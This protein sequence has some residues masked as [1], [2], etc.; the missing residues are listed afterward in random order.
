MIRI[1]DEHTINQ[2]AAGEVIENPASVIKELVDNSLDAGATSIIIEATNSGRQLIS[3]KDN[4]HGMSRDDALLCLERYATS[5]IKSIDDL[6]NLTTMGFRGEA[7][8]S[9]AA[10][11]EIMLLTAKNDALKPIVDGTML[12][13]KGGKILSCQQAISLPGT[14]FEVKSLFFN[15]P[16][17]KKF[18]KSPV[19]DSSDILKAVLQLALSNP[20]VAFE[21]TLNQ[22]KEFQLASQSLEERIKATLGREF[23]ATL[24]PIKYKNELLSISGYISKASFSKPTRSFQYLFINQRPVSSYVVSSAVKEAYGSSID[25]ARHPAFLLHVTVNAQFLDVNVHPQKKE[26]RF[27]LDDLVRKAII[28]AVT[29]VLFKAVPRPEP[30]AHAT[31]SFQSPFVPFVPLKEKQEVQMVMPQ[32][33]PQTMSQFQV[34]GFIGS[35]ILAEVNWSDTQRQK[36]PPDLADAEVFV[37][38]AREALSLITY[39]GAKNAKSSVQTLLLPIFMELAPNLSHRLL[40][41]IEGLS[42]IGFSIR[43]FGANA[44]LI[45]SYPNYFEEGELSEILPAFLAKIEESDH[46]LDIAKELALEVRASKRAC[47]LTHT[48]ATLIVKKLTECDDPFFSPFGTK[49]IASISKAEIE[50]KFR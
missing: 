8:S 29:Q 13:A 49:V 23:F 24:L 2:I 28:E 36:M 46:T 16:A 22:K 31:T 11:S 35:Y 17:R 5:K 6:W 27:Q 26:V 33:I 19:K 43:E 37:I 9:I 41:H 45:E 32:I 42:Q 10:V 39:V 20:H 12:H 14:T 15:V 30:I 7:L 18:L 34:M 3:V 50:K 47:A 40:E 38:S 25:P 21:L 48:L 44:F 1:L 4:G